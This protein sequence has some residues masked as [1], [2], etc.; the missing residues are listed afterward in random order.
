MANTVIQIKRSSTTAAP[1]NGSLQ[2]A[3]QAYSFSS[4]KLFIGNTAGS[5]VL[6]IGGKYWVDTTIAAFDQ[7]NAAYTQANTGTT[8]V[9]AFTTANAAY[10]QANTSRT[11]A[12]A[13]FLQANTARDGANTSQTTA[14]AAFGQA[15]TAIEY[16]QPAIF[17]ANAAIITSNAAF[18]QA[19]TARNQANNAYTQANTATTNAGDA[20]DQA[21]TA[22][23]HANA[24]F[25]Q[26][27]TAYNVANTK[28]SSSG[29]T[30]SGDVAIT[31]NLAV[32]GNV[33]SF[34]A[35]NLI[36]ND[37]FILLANNNTGDVNDIGIAGHYNTNSHTGI[38]RSAGTKEWYVFSDYNE[39][40]FYNGG[41]N[42]D[43]SGNNFTLAVLNAYLKTSNLELNGVNAAAWITSAYNQ[44]NT[45]QTTGVAAFG[46]ANTAG[47]D[48][49]NAFAKA[50]SATTD[51]GAAFVQANT[52]RVHANA[53]FLQANTARDTGNTAQTTAVAAFG[54]A[55]TAGT[56]AV[57][58]FAKANAAATL[59]FSTVSVSGTSL[60]ADSASDTLTLTSG[61]G[62][63]LIADA[64]T[65]SFNVSLSPTGVTATT[66]GGADTVGRFTVDAWGRITSAANAAI[67]ISAA[68]ITSGTLGV[69][70]G[71]TGLTTVTTNGILY[72]QGGSALAV[73][74]AGTEGQ[75]LQASAAG[76]PS[77]AHLDGGSF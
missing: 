75:V 33:T 13:A 61:N 25:L 69:D 2:P 68:A 72:G 43:L 15:N 19:N 50:N 1:T 31:G 60:V 23:V 57:N 71:G 41:G 51:A 21:N 48:A 67:A 47:T 52:A 11:H 4:D 76:V 35:N 37:P 65:D 40:F 9:A 27:N 28:F 73:T 44:A 58:A 54:K 34:T 30:I 74:S 18:D 66:Y 36:I 20:F 59:S 10:A 7:A 39:H 24:A 55:N 3:E 42:I 32:T 46:K 38:F 56:D 6:E 14:V 64:G 16:A 63:I 12:N 53:A 5:G 17:T 70:R 29:G 77:F 49:V 26:A 45:A 8:A 62:V 22:R